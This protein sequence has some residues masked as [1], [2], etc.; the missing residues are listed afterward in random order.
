MRNGV[1]WAMLACASVIGAADTAAAQSATQSATGGWYV[2]GSAGAL[3]RMDASRSGT[4]NNTATGATAPGTNTFAF[5]PGFVGN[6]GVGY[7]LPI[8]VRLEAELGYA[9]YLVSAVYPVSSGPVAFFNG[10]GLGRQSAG[11]YDQ[12]T[13]TANA[14]YDLP[15]AGKVVPYIGGGFG[16][17]LTGFEGG[18]FSSPAG[19]GR[20]RFSTGGGTSAVM[21]VILGELGLNIA[22]APNW[23]VVPAYRFAHVFNSDGLP[24]NENIF[25]VGLRYSF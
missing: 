16:I 14:F 7:K 12:G 17:S 5:S 20:V 15:I 6:L 24:Y 2:E 8:G 10:G 3:F 18:V 13:A 25:K 19:G 9:H 1:G 11:G 22:V 23:T 21:P 4:F